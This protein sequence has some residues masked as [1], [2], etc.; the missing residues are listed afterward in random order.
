[1]T[2]LYEIV[3]VA[4]MIVQNPS[5]G[6]LTLEYQPLDYYNSWKT[7]RQEQKR[8]SQTKDKRTGYICVK[9]DRN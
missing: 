6:P 8:L 9:V 5:G 2:P 4:I 1:M 3:L 7:C